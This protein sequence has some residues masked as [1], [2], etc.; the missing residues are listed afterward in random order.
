MNN[1]EII[2]NH[3]I[4]KLNE[5]VVPWRKDWKDS[6]RNG[7]GS[8]PY[9]LSNGRAYRGI[10]TLTLLCGGYAS[11]GWATYKQAQTLGYQVRKG[12][13]STPVVWWS[14]PDRKTEPDR[15]PYMKLYRVFNVE[16]LDGVPGNLPLDD[17][18]EPFDGIADADAMVARY[19]E[20]ASHPTLGH[21]GSSAYFSPSHDHVQMPPTDAF[22]TREGYYA[23]LFH[24]FVHS[25]GIRG[26][27]EREE[28]KGIKRFGDM[29]YSKEELTAEFGAAFLCGEAGISNADLT[30]NHA[31]YIH[32]WLKKLE[33][34]KTFAVQ[35]AQRAQRAADYILGRSRAAE[36]E[37]TTVSE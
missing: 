8:M 36:T 30:N 4:S 5:G 1:Y 18:A 14:F 22:S 19:M 15:A 11:N 37:E 13:K 34:D 31:A 16:Q 9:N 35:A 17:G 33:S 20:S 2:T 3:L 27:C 26:R 7:G 12:E 32:G 28:L 10:N 24:E 23:T 6:K 29:E 25:T 21:G